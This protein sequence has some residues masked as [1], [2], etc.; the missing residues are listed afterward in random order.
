M[1]H[2]IVVGEAEEGVGA[3]WVWKELIGF[4]GISGSYVVGLAMGVGRN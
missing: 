2:G 4:V 1:S 3:K